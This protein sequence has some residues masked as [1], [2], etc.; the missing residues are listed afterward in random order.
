MDRVAGRP[1]PTGDRPETGQAR[2]PDEPDPGLAL[3]AAQ[4]GD[5]EAF[6]VLYRDIQ[7]RLLRY[8]RAL[9]G[10]DAEDV[11]SETW[12]QVARDLGGFQGRLRRVP[13][14]G[15]DCWPAPGSRSPA[16]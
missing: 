2:A 15:G 11:A 1:V 12:L 7:P 6:R 13:R 4:Q 3:A 14:L 8:L 5:T 9:V 16:P 10:E